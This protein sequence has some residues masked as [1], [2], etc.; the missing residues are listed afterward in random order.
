V[1]DRPYIDLSPDVVMA[2][3]PDAQANRKRINL[4]KAGHNIAHVNRQMQNYASGAIKKANNRT[5]RKVAAVTQKKQPVATG[6]AL[7]S[8]SRFEELPTQGTSSSATVGYKPT[9]SYMPTSRPEFRRALEASDLTS[10]INAMDLLDALKTVDTSE[11]LRRGEVIGAMAKN[12]SNWAMNMDRSAGG[13]RAIEQAPTVF[14]NTLGE[15]TQSRLQNPATRDA[16]NWSMTM[17]PPVTGITPLALTNNS[18]VEMK[19]MSRIVSKK[20]VNDGALPPKVSRVAASVI[21]LPKVM[22]TTVGNTNGARGTTLVRQVNKEIKARNKNPPTVGGGVPYNF[23]TA[24]TEYVHSANSIPPTLR[25]LPPP[26]PPTVP[27]WLPLPARRKRPIEHIV[28]IGKDKNPP[29]RKA[30]HITKPVF[31]T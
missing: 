11:L 28:Q 30:N 16:H 25:A 4:L 14:Q 13:R 20:R 1:T 29:K 23:S 31:V 6:V 26:Q 2:T 22:R 17:P 27:L 3:L 8:P 21:A 7:Q 12:M 5:K 24:P 10:K 9:A 15:V 19:K 18:D